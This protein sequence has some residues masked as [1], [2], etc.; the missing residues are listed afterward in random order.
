MVKLFYLYIFVIGAIF[1]SF[2]YVVGT[3][4]SNN[5]SLI[6]PS[7]HCTYCNHKLS[8]LEL[9]PILSFLF[10]R[11]KCHYCH[12][13]LSIEYLI[14]EVLTGVLFLISY[15]KFHISYEFFVMLIISSLLVLIFI[16]DFKYM[17]ILDSPLVVSFVL[18]VLLKFIY[19][20][21]Y[22]VLFSTLYG[23]LSFFT[24]LL[25]GK[26]GTILFK[27][28]SLG[29]G[30]IKFS[31]IIGLILD[32]KF[33]MVALVFSTFLALP[34]AIGSIFLQ[35]ENEVPFG[36]FLVSSLFLVFYFFEKFQY[37]LFFL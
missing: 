36:P 34:Y 6:K 29:G 15:M 7:S 1:G 37:V 12:K 28:E 23:I 13:K 24:M 11:G 26:I 22:T 4:L 2:Y 20:D 3:R 10:L 27:K 8:V 32:Y 18:L 33:A 35:K 21:I 31:F 16:T 14:Y 25:I 19:F 30:D 5:E 9:I 17:I